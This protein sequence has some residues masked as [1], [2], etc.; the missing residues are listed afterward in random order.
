[1]GFRPATDADLERAPQQENIPQGFRLATE[2][3]LV[4][5]ED[6]FSL[7]DQL[8]GFGKGVVGGLQ[9]YEASKLKSIG[10]AQKEAALAA[11]A[12]PNRVQIKTF[13][14]PG[15]GTDEQPYLKLPENYQPS[16]VIKKIQEES[17]KTVATPVQEQPIYKLGQK[18]EK[19]VYPM[20]QPEQ[21]TYGAKFGQAFG[22]MAGSFL[23]YAV[24]R[25][26]GKP[27]ELVFAGTASAEQTGML[28]RALQQKGV[29]EPTAIEAANMAGRLGITDMF[30][31]E[32]L[33]NL[34]SKFG[35]AK[36]GKV[37]GMLANIATKNPKKVAALVGG[38]TEALQ[39]TS[40]TKMENMIAA[41]YFGGKP[42]SLSE[43]ALTAGPAGAVMGF[44]LGALGGKPARVPRTNITPDTSGTGISAD[45]LGGGGP[46]GPAEGGG[47]GTTSWR[48]QQIEEMRKGLVI[49]PEERARRNQQLINQ[50]DTES[51]IQQPV[52]SPVQSTLIRRPIPTGSQ[53]R[54]TGPAMG[55][56]PTEP[57]PMPQT[58]ESKPPPVFPWHPVQDTM[59]QVFKDR[60][61]A[62]NTARELS[63]QHGVNYHV[64]STPNG[65][66][67]RL[68]PQPQQGGPAPISRVGQPQE[69]LGSEYEQWL[70]SLGQS[71]PELRDFF[72]QLE[73]EEP[74]AQT[75][76][77]DQGQLSSQ[78]R[79]G[80]KVQDQGGQDLQR[81]Q[82]TQRTEAEQQAQEEVV[83]QPK[84]REKITQLGTPEQQEARK[85]ARL[86]MIQDA[87]ERRRAERTAKTRPSE[88]QPSPQTAEEFEE[89]LANEGLASLDSDLLGENYQDDRQS[90][91]KAEGA[92]V[93][94]PTGEPARTTRRLGKVKSET[95]PGTGVGSV[96][97]D[98]EDLFRRIAATQVVEAMND[99][100]SKNPAVRTQAQQ[101]F[102]DNKSGDISSWKMAAEL[103]G[104]PEDTAQKI[105][106]GEFD[107]ETA[108]KALKSY[109]LGENTVTEDELSVD[110]VTGMSYLYSFGGQQESTKWDSKMIRMI[111]SDRMPPLVTKDEFLERVQAMQ[112]KGE[113][114]SEEWDDL[115]RLTDFPDWINK[116]TDNQ[117]I[118]REAIVREL[119]QRHVQV[120]EYVLDSEAKTNKFTVYSNTTGE[121][122]GLDID[123]DELEQYIQG[124]QAQGVD[125]DDISYV[126]DKYGER[127][128]PKYPH[129]TLNK[130]QPGRVV[131]IVMTSPQA[132]E[133]EED[134]GH[135]VE[136]QG[137]KQI[138]WGRLKFFKDST[139]DKVMNIEEVQSKRHSKGHDEGYADV[140]VTKQRESL[141]NERKKL[142]AE[143]TK[144]HTTVIEPY[145]L[146]ILANPNDV[147]VILN[148]LSY[149]N[150]SVRTEQALKNIMQA[151]DDGLIRVP[152][153]VYKVRYVGKKSVIEVGNHTVSK[154]QMPELR[155]M[156]A[157][158][159]AI[160]DKLADLPR[161]RGMPDAPF[162]KSWLT[163]A[164]RRLLRMAADE[165]VR[166]LSWTTGEQQA[167]RWGL[168]QVADR[169]FYH[170]SNHTLVGYKNAQRMF[171]HYVTPEQL[172]EYVG[173]K[174][175]DQLT[176]KSTWPENS[177]DVPEDIEFYSKKWPQKI[178][179]FQGKLQAPF[180]GAP[181]KPTPGYE[182]SKIATALKDAMVP[183]KPKVTTI[184]AVDSST[185]KTFGNQPGIELTEEQ[186]EHYRTKPQYL[187]SFGGQMD[188]NEMVK[189]HETIGLPG[190]DWKKRMSRGY[191]NWIGT[192]QGGAMRMPE[193]LGKLFKTATKRVNDGLSGFVNAF[194]ALRE[195]GNMTK[196]EQDLV[197]KVIHQIDGQEIK[198][199]PSKSITLLDNGRVEVNPQY[200]KEYNAWVDSKPWTD[201][202]KSYFKSKDLAS[203][204]AF[205]DLHNEFYREGVDETTL[206]K[207]RNHIGFI[208]NHYPH[209]WYGN[210]YLIGRDANGN[211]RAH[212]PIQA[213]LVDKKRGNTV[214]HIEA[215]QQIMNDPKW[216]SAGVA[217][218]DDKAMEVGAMEKYYMDSPVPV[219]VINRV[220]QEGVDRAEAKIREYES[221]GKPDAAEKA[222]DL[223]KMATAFRSVLE[224]STATI[225]KGKGFG[226]LMERQGR[227]GYETENIHDV[228]FDYF[229]GVYSSIAKLKAARAYTSDMFKMKPGH[230]EL[231]MLTDFI[232][233][234]MSPRSE[235]DN[236]VARARGGLYLWFLAGRIRSGLVNMTNAITSGVPLLSLHSTGAG[237]EFMRAV[238]DITMQYMK[239]PKAIRGMPDE[240]GLVGV[241]GTA[242]GKGNRLNQYELRSMI[243]LFNEGNTQA[244]LFRELKGQTTRGSMWDGMLD[245]LG[246]PM[247]VSEWGSR[248]SIALAAY[249]SMR[250][251]KIVNQR[252]LDEFGL[253]KGQKLDESVDAD[254]A[255]LEKF[256]EQVVTGSHGTFARYAKPYLFRH[257]KVGTV[258]SPF[259]TFRYF[260]QHMMELW[261]WL[262]SKQYNPERGKQAVTRSL[263]AQGVFGGLLKGV[264]LA[265][266]MA[267]LW[268]AFTDRDPEEDARSVIDWFG[269]KSDTLKDIILYGA[270]A[271]IGLS[272]GS[273]FDTNLPD[274]II[275]GISMIATGLPAD[276]EARLKLGQ[277]AGGAVS[278]IVRN[279]IGAA[280]SWAN[281]NKERAMEYLAPMFI[282]QVLEAVR[283]SEGS[284]SISGTPL[285]P[286]MQG[287]EP[288]RY[289]TMEA[290]G[291]GLG[292]GVAREEKQWNLRQGLAR[293]QDKRNSVLGHLASRY[294]NAMNSGDT[295]AQIGVIDEL[296]AWNLTMIGKDRVDMAI[297]QK[298]FEQSV[299]QRMSPRRM[300]EQMRGRQM[301]LEESYGLGQ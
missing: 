122:Y 5:S 247:A 74:N 195:W 54:T 141:E 102:Q 49:T 214:K 112:N 298:S 45:E 241:F 166:K 224:K 234:D 213:G 18:V 231:K 163:L 167:T 290:V 253:T 182:S 278:G 281:G 277:E 64:W 35:A 79:L 111:G 12:E 72:T 140:E 109:M 138:F 110:P 106:R 196:E 272:V 7:G 181:L 6:Q 130:D 28:E 52:P 144:I 20:T 280:Q 265:Y 235:L 286:N 81:N 125:P 57:L 36:G 204:Q 103:L 32:G 2:D 174:L 263:I 50:S 229:H 216:A 16:G 38:L 221:S 8:K 78:R 177:V 158:V 117:P 104:W 61:I 142:Q 113:F 33:V 37:L 136:G 261:H 86:A 230:N 169:L 145:A 275:E 270:P 46:G 211:P 186:L 3:D 162:R 283:K 98:T 143:I 244:Q 271:G 70:D 203:R 297:T 226:N 165:G 101:W 94:E 202:V 293:Q 251:G 73:Q 17:A 250:D 232:E 80:E 287:V 87:A 75:L 77:G 154:R 71:E 252:T 95:T 184:N 208:P 193:T 63:K 149:Y 219:D 245:W 123:G 65:Y 147:N 236:F 9:S 129:Y 108:K 148:N 134:K 22:S 82:E 220:L 267:K 227:L 89:L 175:A 68:G 139:G 179:G 39:E 300:P 84:L 183:W 127:R 29:P 90:I 85:L 128:T 173:Q 31:V 133:M 269:G 180:E 124:L 178:Y 51:R 197:R 222:E 296:M 223:R 40:Q 118:E 114:K 34:V 88:A 30:E 240:R 41:A 151:H 301:E 210:H 291:K 13:G 10:I 276:P 42:E 161:Q 246:I 249:R 259:Y 146:Q 170:R 248:A 164:M 58:T 225:I 194:G 205:A 59:K 67:L 201:R 116:F 198:A 4:Q 266:T 153:D 292:F 152:A 66:E 107:A 288:L 273:S 243:K 299:R 228:Y 157:Q 96:T 160:D 121:P 191:W 237:T 285:P 176:A 150:F 262:G 257:G 185:L 26:I 279:V 1:M 56:L 200:T 190:G 254:R 264:P 100:K 294:V 295:G 62:E 155:D 260:N 44:I 233:D 97:P 91:L 212:I 159:E 274:S 132:G 76:R 207:L 120:D 69:Q 289:S 137:K 126:N 48:D 115:W 215:I 60:T 258:L 206:E 15:M 92:P 24:G 218:W 25:K 188:P 99:L 238:K 23:D 282:R 268:G 47:G 189:I 83:Q 192:P 156:L 14:F 53:T 255:K 187:Y 43:T 256:A 239:E 217:S 172:P 55:V 199:I 171:E 105:L 11:T 21:Q 119:Q 19:P 27:S 242:S 284:Y 209:I 131:E 93:A 135:Y 168:R